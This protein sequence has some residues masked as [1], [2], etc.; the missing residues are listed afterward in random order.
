MSSYFTSLGGEGC[1]GL[2]YIS[3]KCL[4]ICSIAY[5]LNILQGIQSETKSSKKSLKVALIFLLDCA[6]LLLK[7]VLLILNYLKS[8]MDT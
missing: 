4:F 1:F 3:L 8:E 6:N 2:L 7:K 5:G